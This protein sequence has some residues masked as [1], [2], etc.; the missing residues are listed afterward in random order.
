MNE[1][2]EKIAFFDFCDTLVPFQSADAYVKFVL[3]HHKSFP[4]LMRRVFFVLLRN[5][6]LLNWYIQK[7]HTSHKALVLWQLKGLSE[8]VMRDMAKKFY[9]TRIKPTLISETYNC[10]KKRQSDGY[11]IVLVSG[12]Y[13]IYLHL[14][15]AD[16]GINACDVFSTEL[17]FE[18]GVFSGK[19]V[20][21]CMNELKVVRV[22]KKFDQKKIYSV[23]YSD[24][25]S[26][27]PLLTW[28][29]EAFLVQYATS[30]RSIK[31]TNML[32]LLYV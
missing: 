24:S 3:K 16:N 30:N 25:L 27:L 8:S 6:H 17:F 29:D 11:R 32:K 9:D 10:L 1:N 22:E 13:D 4:M 14:F 20:S 28:C 26:D 21:D 7:R 18:N 2:K 19:Y 12:G 23:A 15:A 5:I 31:K